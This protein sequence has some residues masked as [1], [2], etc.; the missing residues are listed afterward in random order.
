MWRLATAVS[1]QAAV[2]IENARLYEQAQQLAAL[3]ERQRL[4]RELHDSVSQAL[5]GIALGARTA[6]TLDR[7]ETPDTICPNSL[8]RTRWNMYSPW[9]KRVWPKCGHSF[10]NCAPNRWKQRA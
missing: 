6:H 7:Q 4:A 1:N 10:L 9:P 2:A 8:D 3:Q 5:Y